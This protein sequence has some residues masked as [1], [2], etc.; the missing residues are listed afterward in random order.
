[1]S[2]PGDKKKRA[3]YQDVLDA[4]EHVVAEIIDGELFT[5][6]R[7][8]SPH[9][10]VASR[11]GGL[12]VPPFDIGSN[13]P[14]GWILLDEPELHIVGEIVVPDL[15]GWHRERLPVIPDEAYF[16]LAPDW[17]CEILSKGTERI[18]RGKK[19]PIYARAGVSH[20][21]LLH[22]AR[23]F[24]EVYQLQEG[25]WLQLA[26]HLGDQPVRVPP[27]DAIELDLSLL[28]ADVEPPSRASESSASYE[29]DEF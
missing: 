13:G 12:L 1:V 19:M 2:D 8:R 16:T 17:V 9:A 26:V 3:T 27:F 23:R 29:Y 6:P 7:P 4:P 14:G 25:K 5:M 18:D 24:L 22:P 28:W 10:R 20:A 11:L 21:W 15:A